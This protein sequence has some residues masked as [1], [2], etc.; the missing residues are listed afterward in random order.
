VAEKEAAE[1]KLKEANEQ[2]TQLK[3]AKEAAESEAA[4]AKN[5]LEAERAAREA[6]ELRASP[7]PQPAQPTTEAPQP[8][9]PSP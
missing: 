2:L 3:A 8:Q 5:D 1:G 7:L 9:A 6:A 4:Q